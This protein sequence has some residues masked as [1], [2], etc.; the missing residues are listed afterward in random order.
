MVLGS[1]FPCRSYAQPPGCAVP[2]PNPLTV[3]HAIA[4]GK[5]T[6]EDNLRSF[7]LITP[8]YATH[9]IGKLLHWLLAV[10]HDVHSTHSYY[11]RGCQALW[12]FLKQCAVHL[13]AGMRWLYTFTH[14]WALF[15]ADAGPDIRLL[16]DADDPG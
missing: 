9:L 11:Q 2:A 5:S 14:N 6:F 16:P 3:L 7:L 1:L 10:A 15:H 13:S 4:G 8:Q 12:C